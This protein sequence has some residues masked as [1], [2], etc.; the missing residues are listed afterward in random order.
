[1]LVGA[2]ISIALQRVRDKM[3][4][5]CDQGVSQG[6]KDPDN[7]CTEIKRKDEQIAQLQE[8]MRKILLGPSFRIGRAIVHP[9]STAKTWLNKH[10]GRFYGL[11]ERL[12]S[13]IAG[14]SQT[15]ARKI[16]L[17]G[18]LRIQFGKHRSGWHFALQSL[19][20]LHRFHGVILDP[21]IEMTFRWRPEG[22][23]PHVAPWIGFIHVPP[24]IPRW[25]D[26]EQANEVI[27]RSKAWQE[28]LPHCKGL[29]AL[30]EYHR[31]SLMKMLDVPVNS[32]FHPTE[33]PGTQW[34]WERFS[35]NKEKK[36]VQVGWWLRKLHAIYQLPETRYRKIFLSTGHPSLSRLME[37]ERAVIAKE[38]TFCDALYDTATI[39][40]Y[41][42]IRAYDKLLSE[43][44]IFLFL[45]DAS[46]SNTVIECIARGTPLLVNPIEPV[47]EYL[48][49][50]YP[51]YYTSL[52]EAA[53][54][55]MDLDLINRTHQFLKSC[56]IRSKLTADHFLESF[57]R[58]QIYQDL[59]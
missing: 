34:T 18:Q 36:I 35:S 19:G 13:T 50:D 30:S 31:K 26:Y 8:E 17:S 15:Y 54:K 58:S 24:G 47:R 51:F 48:G 9:A 28:S 3:I 39:V 12:L 56:P 23:R 14:K 38:D 27:F 32:L 11:S 44:I 59:H 16:D 6:V 29:F 21:F 41:L 1:V 46:A 37:R 57:Y 52:E 42:S 40:P 33:F 20:P 22:V 25:F 49:A 10:S 7:V 43:N 4:T 45:Y 53:G 5:K 2:V 55:A